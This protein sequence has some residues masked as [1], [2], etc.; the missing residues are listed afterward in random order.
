MF[1]I[2][3][4]IF[5]RTFY[6]K[7]CILAVITLGILLMFLLMASSSACN[8]AIA[9]VVELRTLRVDLLLTCNFQDQ[10]C[11]RSDE[12]WVTFSTPFETISG[13]HGKRQTV[14]FGSCQ[15]GKCWIFRVR[16]ENMQKRHVFSINESWPVATPLAE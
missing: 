6:W 2:K 15:S 11:L 12:S 13:N 5:L 10:V 16:V 1:H 14:G 7:S 9:C 3:L 8:S 4:C